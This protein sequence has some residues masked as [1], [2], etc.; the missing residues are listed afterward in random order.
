MINFK[1]Y[2]PTRIIF[3]R[4]TYKKVGEEVQNYGKKVLMV[5]GGKSLKANGTYDEVVKS[6]EAAGIEFCELEGV[7][8]NPRLS[9][10][11]EGIQLAREQKV[12]LILAVGGGSVIDTAKAVAA[13]MC[14]DGDV[15]DFY[16]TEKQPK[17]VMPVGVVLT[18]P[19]AGSESSDGSVITKE[20]GLLKRS[21]CTD[22]F[23]PKFAILDPQLCFTLPPHQISAGGCDILAHVME[24]YFV[25]DDHHD[26]SDRLCEAAMISLIENLPKVLENKKD[27]DAWAE[28]M[29]IGNIAHNGL[30]G[31]GKRDDWGSHDIEHQLS[32]HYDIAH[33]AGL[34]IIFPAWMKYVW[35]EKPEMMEQ[36]ALRVWHVSPE[37][38]TQEEVVLEGIQKTEDFY[39]SI[40][41]A[42]RLSRV[43]ID[44]RDFAVMAKKAVMSGPLGN[45]KKLYA[46]DVKK[47]YEISL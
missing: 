27:Y 7:K 1:S 45:F 38:K 39:H 30:L 11:Y 47:I 18:I 25:P 13:G 44:D 4:D 3:G 34:A 42:T 9:L 12:D 32:A 6:L 41:L 28:I 33:G 43:G 24:R 23:F 14:Y 15:W 22:L 17:L 26:F 29:W 10:V 40:G 2:N 37:G 5:Y 16:S 31:R 19:A 21:C 35:K 20:E 36:Y 8:P 46:E